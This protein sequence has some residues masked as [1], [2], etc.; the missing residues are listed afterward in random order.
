[1]CL[2]LQDTVSAGKPY[3]Q[4]IEVESDEEPLVVTL[5]WTGPEAALGT[6]TPIVNQ[7]ELNIF[8]EVSQLEWSTETSMEQI[9][10]GLWY[11][12]SLAFRVSLL[13]FLT[14]AR[15]VKRFYIPD[16][17]PGRYRILVKPSFVTDEQDVSLV[18]TG[19]FSKKERTSPVCCAGWSYQA[20]GGCITLD[21]IICI[22]FVA[23]I[24][25]IGVIAALALL[26]RKSAAKKEASGKIV[27]RKEDDTL[28][29][30]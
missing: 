27:A 28:H 20:I 23:A 2:S 30:L 24:V 9:G 1:M 26:G 3:E 29:P 7:V 5:A 25:V 21:A 8:E 22:V 15:A 6:Q 10:N 18:V 14:C 11:I 16:P 12:A 4:F 13:S 17:I 19:R